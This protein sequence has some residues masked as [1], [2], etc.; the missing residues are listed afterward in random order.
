[1][2]KS[3]SDILLSGVDFVKFSDTGG[4]ECLEFMSYTRRFIE[5]VLS[6]AIFVYSI[7]TGLKVR[8]IKVKYLSD[9]ILRAL[10]TWVM[11]TYNFKQLC[12]EF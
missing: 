10:P 11:K 8:N 1:M 2:F 6:L 5:T 4:Q 9:Q 12:I 3:V 7:F